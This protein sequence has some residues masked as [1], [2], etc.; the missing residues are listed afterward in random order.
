MGRQHVVLG[1]LGDAASRV[2]AALPHKAIGEQLPC[3]IVAPGLRRHHRRDHG[4][5]GFGMNLGVRVIRV[6]AAEGFLHELKGVRDPELKRKIVGLI[7][8][9][10]SAQSL[11]ESG[12]GSR[13][14]SRS[15]A[16]WAAVFF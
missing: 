10:S 6:D 3:A 9:L 11:L 8:R 5:Q 4:M 1:R 16:C 2:V 14:V 13:S 7:C 12:P 15:Q